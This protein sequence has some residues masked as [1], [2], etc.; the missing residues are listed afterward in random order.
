MQLRLLA[1]LGGLALLIAGVGIH[2]LLNF[3]VTPRTQELGIRRALGAQ[4]GSILRMVMREGLTLALAG[5]AVGVVVGLFVGRGM[6]ALLFGVPPHDPVA[7]GAAVG[8]CLATAVVG[9]VRPAVRAAGVDP[10]TAMREG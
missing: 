6:S 7:I 1:I 9:C 10:M 2:G 3:A 5:A 4:A 8:L